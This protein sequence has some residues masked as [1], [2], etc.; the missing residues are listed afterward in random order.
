MIKRPVIILFAVASL[1]AAAACQEDRPAP[2]SQAPLEADTLRS[3]SARRGQAQIDTALT[4]L[5]RVD[6]NE[7]AAISLTVA[8]GDDIL[9]SGAAGCAQFS[10]AAGTNTAQTCLRP[11]T[12]RTK[13]RMASVSKMAVAFAVLE[14]EARGLIDLDGD[15]SL[16]LGWQL[17]N[18]A[19]PQIPITARQLLSHT[20]SLRDPAAYW[21]AAPG[22]F[23]DT[24]ADA[25]DIFA[26]PA[27]ADAQSTAPGNYFTYANINY[28]FLATLLEKIAN[29][30]FDRIIT[31]TVAE[32]LGLEAAFNWS[33]LTTDIKQAGATLYRAEDGLWRAQTDD[34][35]ILTQSGPLILAE[36]NLDTAAYLETYTP[37]ENAT[38]FS[39]QGGL[40]AS[41]QD[42]ITLLGY[43]R[44]IP[45][46]KTPARPVWQYDPALQNGDR[47]GGFFNTFGTGIQT[48]SPEETGYEARVFTGHA[49]EA[50][51]LYSGAWLIRGADE[52]QD[53]RIAFA[54]TGSKAPPEKGAFSAFNTLEEG[55]ISLAMRI[56]QDTAP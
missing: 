32:P 55:I 46:D 47:D 37:G 38:L 19:Y 16:Y 11:L 21:V 42:L 35:T 8:R 1:L 36:P 43:L 5:L 9:Y 50:Y 22:S 34:Q 40:R 25:A 29:E 23:Q 12:P 28:G 48:L 33:G 41:T 4:A 54:L 20:S 52:G 30:R 26:P 56:A 3:S 17:R 13:M 24:F 44:N 45:A 53:I 49:G 51:G 15:I 6:Q 31:Q 18:P 7:I 27:P 14:F 2:A 39:P 10:A